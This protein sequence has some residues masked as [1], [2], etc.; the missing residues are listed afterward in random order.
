ME[1]A[2]ASITVSAG[3]VGFVETMGR[4]QSII[5]PAGRVRIHNCRAFHRVEFVSTERGT[6]SALRSSSDV[7]RARIQFQ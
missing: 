4:L 6:Q 5:R 3:Q 7:S 2:L 1:V